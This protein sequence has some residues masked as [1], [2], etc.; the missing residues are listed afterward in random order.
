MWVFRALLV[1]VLIAVLLGFSVYNAGER[2]TVRLLNTPYYGVPLIYIAYWAF[3]FGMVISFLLF[4]TIYFKQSSEIR[5]LK[6]LSESLN[7]EISALRN[8]PI[9]DSSDTFLGAKK[10]DSR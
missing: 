4:V 9:E 7:S 3:L 5:R 8:R 10:E 6:R 2:V 1:V